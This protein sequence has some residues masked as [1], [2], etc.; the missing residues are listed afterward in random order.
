MKKL[1]S[2]Q[3]FLPEEEEPYKTKQ[4]KK[5]IRDGSLTCYMSITLPWLLLLGTQ[6][7]FNTQLNYCNWDKV[8]ISLPPA[9]SHNLFST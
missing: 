7:F 2:G 8:P 9:V 4:K 6:D 5:K 1:L 3:A